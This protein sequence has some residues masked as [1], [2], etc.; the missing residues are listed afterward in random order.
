M[1]P[2]GVVR[3]VLRAGAAATAV[4]AR[5]GRTAATPQQV[6]QRSEKY[7][8]VV[9]GSGFGG[10]VAALRLAKA[11]VRTLVLERGRWWNSQPNADTF[12]RFFHPDRRVSWFEPTP[13]L[14]FSPPAVFKPYSGV[15][16]R[17]HG[18]GMTVFCAAGVGGGSLLYQG[19]SLKPSEELFT[20]DMPEG[21]DYAE[22]NEV[23]YPR[24]AQML[25]FSVVPD[26]ILNHVSY[27]SSRQFLADAARAG[28][29]P[30]RVLQPMNW[31]VIR[32][33]LRAELPRWST[34]GD[35]IYGVN[36]GARFSLDKTYLAQAVA[37]GMVTIAALHRVKHISTGSESRYVVDCDRID[38]DG[39][40]QEQ[41]VIGADALFLGAGSVNTSKL[42]VRARGMGTLPDLPPDVGRFWGSNGDRVYLRTDPPE[43]TLPHQGGPPCAGYL[44]WDAPTGPAT[45]LHGPVPFPTE[46]F[47]TLLGGM[48]IPEGHGQ[49]RYDP[50]TDET[51][52]EWP[53]AADRSAEAALDASVARL[54]RGS[55]GTVISAQPLGPG[56]AHPLG[57]AV[58]GP[59]CDTY[60]RVHDNPGLYVTDSALIPGS[61]GAC[62]PSWTIAALAERCLQGVVDQDVGVVF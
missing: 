38:T 33:E 54:S 37:T 24:V 9:I 40:I 2:P 39:V 49:I 18:S 15:V 13:V 6:V 3:R 56:T 21:I 44:D 53:P 8:A 19:V 22:M 45:V 20:R 61:T 26:D 5:P 57:G 50:G 46:T 14:P 23:F 31:D 34:C 32:Q 52:L 16:E 51:T 48:A 28:L 43:P 62:N 10:S 60:G 12:P 17:I 30:V 25:R 58:I 35:H 11:G 47:S 55:G 36:N 27:T 29:N 7:R 42:L 4:F 1:R 41:V 59:V